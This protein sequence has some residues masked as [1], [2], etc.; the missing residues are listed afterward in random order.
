MVFWFS[1]LGWE[2]INKATSAYMEAH[3]QE[4]CTA[5][6]ATHREARLYL[7]SMLTANNYTSAECFS[8][9][10]Q[11]V[12]TSIRAALSGDIHG[13][14]PHSAYGTIGMNFASRSLLRQHLH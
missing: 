4:D 5:L 8:L 14:L 9:P 12:C 7:S 10:L 6:R 11:L 3:A 1:L 2:G 13:I